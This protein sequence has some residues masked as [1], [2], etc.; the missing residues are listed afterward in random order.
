MLKYTD[1]LIEKYNIDKIFLVTE[2]QKYLDLF[3]KYYGEK[4]FF[5]NSF[6]IYKVNSYNLNPRE[7]HRYLLGLEVLIDALL[8]SK[9]NGL[10]C[11]DSNVSEFA[12]FENNQKF[13]F[14]YKICNGVNSSNPFIALF[15]YK[16]KKLFPSGFG[17]LL[18]K[19]EIITN[20]IN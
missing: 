8:L 1:E 9:C 7:N 19:V 13:E 20:E 18:D 2:E 5:T 6:R 10:L 15:L 16:I 4:V 14:I 11:G 12:R 17:G 3:I